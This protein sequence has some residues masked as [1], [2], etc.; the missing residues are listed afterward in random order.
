MSKIISEWVKSLANRFSKPQTYGGGLEYYIVSHNPQNA[1][2]VDRLTKE[3]ETSRN[4][5][6]WA[7][8]L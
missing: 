3:Y 8:G 7:R 6:Y 5:F 1:A 2:D 4:T